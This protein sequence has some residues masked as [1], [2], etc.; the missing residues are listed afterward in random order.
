MTRWVPI[1]L[2]A[3]SKRSRRSFPTVPPSPFQLTRVSKMMVGA[4]RQVVHFNAPTISLSLVPRNGD[5][6]Y[7]AVDRL[8]CSYQAEI[9]DCGA[10]LKISPAARTTLPVRNVFPQLEQVLCRHFA[11]PIPAAIQS[12]YLDP[13]IPIFVEIPLGLVSLCVTFRRT[14]PRNFLQIQCLL[15]FSIFNFS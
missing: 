12:A 6:P 9:S 3:P 7:R 11:T 2:P 15:K 1:D 8:K 10:I 4:I 5:Y 13:P 14:L